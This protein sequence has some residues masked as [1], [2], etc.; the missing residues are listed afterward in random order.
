MKSTIALLITSIGIIVS[1]CAAAKLPA[2]GERFPSTTPVALGAL[3]FAAI[4]MSAW[5]WADRKAPIVSG[6][7]RT[8]GP[9]PLMLARDIRQP[10]RQ[11]AA[12][13]PSLDG[14]GLIERVDQIIDQ[15]VLPFVNARNAIVQ[16]LGIRQGSELVIDFALGERMLNR[17]WTAAADG[18]LVEARAAIRHAAAAFDALPLDD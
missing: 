2:E 15:Y 11:L 5:R 18:H 7:E 4:G 6:R 13:A 8:A 16:R 9:D 12:D 10:V 1:I 14:A 3:A 17:T